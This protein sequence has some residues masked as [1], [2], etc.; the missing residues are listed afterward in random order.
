MQTIAFLQTV[1]ESAFN[2]SADKQITFPL[3]KLYKG[4]MKSGSFIAHFMIANF[5][6][7]FVTAY[8]ILRHCGVDI[9]KMSF[10]GSIPLTRTPV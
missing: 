4:E 3:S 1:D 2:S 9:G 8:L 7:N 10:L 6:F 5:Y